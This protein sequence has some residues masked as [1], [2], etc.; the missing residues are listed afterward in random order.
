MKG[1]G[2][3]G[4]LG[5]AVR[6]R[7]RRGAVSAGAAASPPHRSGPPSLAWR[8]SSPA[9]PVLPP[10]PGIGYEELVGSEGFLSSGESSAHTRVPKVG[11]KA[12]GLR[13]HY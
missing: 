12:F 7:G 6:G 10:E 11:A 4:G 9:S 2:V 3:G 8:T 1:G 5:A 13:I